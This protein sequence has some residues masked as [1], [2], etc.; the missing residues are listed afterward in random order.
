M[1]SLTH[2]LDELVG[3]VGHVPVR[4]RAHHPD[5]EVA[6]DLQPAQGVRHLVRCLFLGVYIIFSIVC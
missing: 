6:Q 5:H 2:L 4:G 3:D 1:Q